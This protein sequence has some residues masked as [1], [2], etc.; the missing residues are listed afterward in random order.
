MNIHKTIRRLFPVKVGASYPTEQAAKVAAQHLEPRPEAHPCVAIVSPNDPDDALAKRLEKRDWGRGFAFV[1]AHLIGA[2]FGALLGA[3]LAFIFT[4]AGPALTQD[5]PFFAYSAFIY[6]GAFLGLFAAGFFSFRLDQ[7]ALTYAMLDAKHQG[8]WLVIYQSENGQ[9][10]DKVKS[11]LAKNAD[12]V[13]K[14][15]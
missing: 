6:V 4:L 11:Q 12:K 3:A 10:A 13:I 2:A 15:F 14:T 9:H 7:D 8:Q 1:K 5:N